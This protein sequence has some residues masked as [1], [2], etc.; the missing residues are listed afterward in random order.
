MDAQI[1]GI[2]LFILILIVFIFAYLNFFS[3]L[4]GTRKFYEKVVGS[5][6]SVQK[7]IKFS[8]DSF[9]EIRYLTNSNGCFFVNGVHSNAG[10]LKWWQACM[11]S[12]K[13]PF[14]FLAKNVSSG[15]HGNLLFSGTYVTLDFEYPIGD[16]VFFSQSF[17]YFI[18]TQNI[19][20]YDEFYHSEISVYTCKENYVNNS[21]VINNLVDCLLKNSESFALIIKNSKVHICLAD[22]EFYQLGILSCNNET[23]VRSSKKGLEQI[24][25]IINNVKFILRDKGE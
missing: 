9:N 4:P 21:F 16:V 11:Y 24:Y 5:S 7:G 19:A 25:N 3:L 1:L 12:G 22:N 13:P 14:C 10:V 8:N 23:K 17:N 15:T 18:N 20:R 2:L 6:C